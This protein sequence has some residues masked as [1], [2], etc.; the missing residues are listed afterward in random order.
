MHRP[1]ST[2][3]LPRTAAAQ[4]Q[5]QPQR[6]PPPAPDAREVGEVVNGSTNPF[7]EDEEAS[8]SV[9]VG[10]RRCLE[11]I[12]GFRQALPHVHAGFLHAYL[13]VRAE[14]LASVKRALDY[15]YA[16]IYLTGHSLGGALAQLVRPT[17]AATT[18]PSLP[19]NSG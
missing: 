8:G 11:R 3:S 16:P 10:C 18:R 15:E 12:P 5:K 13:S 1:S 9:S 2:G 4:A 19:A 17:G 14:V 7:V 6:Q